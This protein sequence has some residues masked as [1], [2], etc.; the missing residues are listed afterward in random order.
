MGIWV[1]LAYAETAQRRELRAAA[2]GAAT[3]I[4]GTFDPH[5]VARG[6]AG[7]A[8]ERDPRPR[9]R[10]G[11][12][13]PRGQ[14]ADDGVLRRPRPA[15]DAAVY[16]EGGAARAAT[17][18]RMACCAAP[19]SRSCSAVVLA[20]ALSSALSD[21]ASRIEPPAARDLSR[22]SGSRLLTVTAVG[23]RRRRRRSTD[24]S[25]RN[26]TTSVAEGRRTASD[27]FL[28]ASGGS[29]TTSG[30]SPGRVHPA[31]ARRRR[32]WELRPTS[33]TSCRRTRRTCPVPHSLEM[34]MLAELGDRWSPRR[35]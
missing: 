20:A 9:L 7:D 33:T 28:D 34:Q 4:A 26:G 23:D 5:S 18:P 15:L 8:V 19:G 6:A 22:R 24:A 25:R 1:W 12:D 3:M 35:C 2:F 31:S 29:A 11:T 14:P 17:R 21:V 10:A 32:R 30:G 13:P 27:R 16:S